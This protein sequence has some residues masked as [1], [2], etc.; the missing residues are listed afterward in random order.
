MDE[1]K[2]VYQ[3]ILD[4][5][6]MSKKYIFSEMCD[7]EWEEMIHEANLKCDVYKEFGEPA[8]KLYRDMFLAIETYKESKD[9]ETKL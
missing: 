5:W 6:N 4:I 1:K 9:K 3:I 7:K 2:L 8:Q